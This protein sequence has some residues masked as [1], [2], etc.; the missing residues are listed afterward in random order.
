[1]KNKGVVNIG[2][3]R[4]ILAELDRARVAVLASDFDSFQNTAMRAILLMSAA[5]MAEDKPSGALTSVG[6][7]RPPAC[8]ASQE[9][10]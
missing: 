1:M 6:W 3:V 9:R 5:K 4:M 8:R 7:P 2:T 10:T